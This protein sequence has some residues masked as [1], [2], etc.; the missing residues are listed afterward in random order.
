MPITIAEL[1]EDLV[2][3]RTVLLFGA[4]ASVQCNAPS[5]GQLIKKISTDFK[6]PAEGLTLRELSALAEAKRNRKDL[7][8]LIRH[9][10]KETRAQGAILNLPLYDWKSLFTTNYDEV[11]EAAYQRCSKSLISFSSNF[12]FTVHP[13]PTATKLFKLHG[14]LS[15]DVVDGTVSRMT[16]TDSDYDLTQD[17]R[18]QLYSR[19][20][21]DLMEAAQVVIIGQSLADED[22]RGVIQKVIEIHKKAYTGGR[23]ALLLYTPDPNRAA[24][25]ELR[26]IRVT[27]GGVDDFFSALARKQPDDK[28]V[29]INTPDL[30]DFSPALRAETNSADDDVSPTRSDV[31]AMFNGWPAKFADISAGLTFERTITGELADFL[32]NP[33]SICAVLLGAS[34]VGKT[35]AARQVVL[36]LRA[37]GYIAWE[38]KSDYPLNAQQWRIVAANL[39]ASGQ[40][41]VLLIDEA[42]GQL[43]EVNELVD[44]LVAA[45]NKQ[46]K[47]VLVSTRNHW[48]PRVKT[49]N[50]Y[51]KGK[52]FLMSQLNGTEIDRLLTVVETVPAMRSLVEAGFGGFSRGEQRRRLVDRCEADMFVCL[53]NIFASEKFDDIILREFAGLDL[54]ERDVYRYVAAMEHSGI[55]VHRQLVMRLLGIEANYVSASLNNLADIVSEYDIDRREGIYGWRVRHGVIAAIITKYKFSDLEQ[56]IALFN[57]V[58]ENISP[59]FDIEIR[60]IREL[61]NIESGIAVIPDRRRQNVLF[62]KMMSIAPGERVPRHRL[63]RN[64]IELGE[65]EK[66][67][68]E[69]RIFEKD[70]RRDGPVVRYR[71]LLMIARATETKDILLEDRK[72]I[73]EQARTLAIAACNQ[74]DSNKTI[75]AAYCDLGIATFKLTGSYTV[76]DAAMIVLR[77]AETRLG[78]PDVTKVIIKYERRMSS[79]KQSSQANYRPGLL[80]D[81]GDQ[82]ETAP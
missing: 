73:L 30:L 52:E 72:A 26:G 64:L 75:L 47:M 11:V 36:K 29:Q 4:G 77:K 38:H 53:K 69:I 58:I 25:Y 24:V 14:T 63:I 8:N 56:L 54:A 51:A 60:T 62:R 61:C 44:S 19:F 49:P 28:Q 23:I 59:T 20:A 16:I 31:S 12:D 45:G 80:D 6:I 41:G 50:L 9:E 65:F 43:Y 78:D 37:G 32:R 81:E 21:T 76:Y 33:E 10:F 74:Y 27:F 35:T 17:F 22:L 48:G 55:R 7:V 18:E 39:A 2:P 68:S 46:F 1:V 5:V 3:Q 34:G 67:E 66:A 82:G 42:H 15:K 57:N 40:S 70:F 71:I 13:D 79:H